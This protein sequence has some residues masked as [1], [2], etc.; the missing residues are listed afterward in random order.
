MRSD[1]MRALIAR[2]RAGDDGSDR[3]GHGVR[4]E[5][6]ITGAKAEE[7]FPLTDVARPRR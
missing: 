6:A 5:P 3:A 2:E 1:D 4:V 7:T